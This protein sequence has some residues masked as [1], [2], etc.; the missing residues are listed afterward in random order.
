MIKPAKK[1]SPDDYIFSV[2]S[3]RERLVAALN[4]TREAFK[5]TRLRPL[6]LMLQ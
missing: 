6:M 5:G 1:V 2:L 3:P 4:I